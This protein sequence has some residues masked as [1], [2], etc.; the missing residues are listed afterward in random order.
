MKYKSMTLGHVEEN[1][2]VIFIVSWSYSTAVQSQ[3]AVSAYF[4]GGLCQTSHTI[5]VRYAAFAS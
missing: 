2:A 3:E 4:T 1:W 5:I